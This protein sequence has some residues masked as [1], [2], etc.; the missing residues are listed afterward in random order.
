MLLVDIRD[1]ERKSVYVF[2]DKVSQS[3]TLCSLIKHKQIELLKNVLNG[4][5]EELIV[6]VFV[7]DL[8]S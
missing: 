1:K 8:H 5:L 7:W 3:G 6:C 4:L 2:G